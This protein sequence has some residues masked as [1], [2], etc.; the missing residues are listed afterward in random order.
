MEVVEKLSNRIILIN[1]GKIVADGSFDELRSQSMEG[2]LERIFKQ[3]TGFN[4]HEKIAK[5]I[6]DTI[7][8]VF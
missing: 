5:E 3:L 8:G 2:S 7:R 6:V 4:E 1:N